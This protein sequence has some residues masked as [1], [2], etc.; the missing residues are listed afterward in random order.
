MILQ[1]QLRKAAPILLV[2]SMLTTGCSSAIEP[3]DNRLSVGVMLADDGLGDRS[4]NDTAYSGLIKARDE[5]DITFNYKELPVT[6]TY[7]KGFDE[8]IRENH[9]VIIGVGFSVQEELEKAAR[10]HPDK[11]FVLIDG[12]SGVENVTSVTFKEHEGSYLLGIIAGL[13]TKTNVVGFIGGM[14]V[15]VIH[16]FGAGFEAGIKEVNPHATVLFRYANNFGD[17]AL[18]AKLASDLI[19]QNADFIYPAAGFTGVG[20]LKEA[21]KHHVY[22][23]GTDSDQFHVAEKSVVSSMLK[24][25]DVGIIDVIKDVQDDGEFKSKDTVLG[26]KENGVSAAPIRVLSL[27]HNEQA[28]FNKYREKLVNSEITVPT[29]IKNGGANQ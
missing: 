22:A 25:V 28:I 6:K 9:D 16:K 20:A 11:K 3:E 5:L 13:K 19:A 18:G 10:K 24:M 27:N 26:L 23:F 14:D 4:F 15:P 17:D 21:E 1:K 12:E 29:S 7:E 2:T 8:L